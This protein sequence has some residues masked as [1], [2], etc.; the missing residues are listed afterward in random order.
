M[1]EAIKKIPEGKIEDLRIRI[2]RAQEELRTTLLRAHPY[3][4]DDKQGEIRKHEHA[5]ELLQLDL[6]NYQANGR[7]DQYLGVDDQMAGLIPEFEKA[8]DQ[9]AQTF[10][11]AFT[12]CK[13]WYQLRAEILEQRGMALET[14]SRF[15]WPEP[16]NISQVETTPWRGKVPGGPS[17]G[18]ALREVFKI[19]SERVIQLVDQTGLPSKPDTRWLAGKR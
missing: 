3:K 11:Y 1:S 5:I 12:A 10:A 16:R 18:D 13:T 8:A 7:I 4:R 2:E 9:I 17:S 14:A 15:G 19:F 6:S